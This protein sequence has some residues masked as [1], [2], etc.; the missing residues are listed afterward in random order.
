MAMQMSDNQ[1]GDLLSQQQQNR[2]WMQKNP[3]LGMGLGAGL[4]GLGGMFSGL[5]SGGLTGKREKTNQVPLY[6]PQIMA[7]KNQMPQE[8]WSQIMGN[9]FDFGPIEDLAR[10]NFQSKTMPSVMNRFNMGSNRG[11][12]NQQGALGAASSGLDAQLAAMRQGFGQQRQ[13]LLASLMGPALQPS[14]ENVARPRQQGG[15]EQGIGAILQMLPFLLSM[16]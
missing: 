12:S 4:A 14:F 2:P 5:M 8:L 10:Q 13:S 3:E 7:L 11:S 16:A 15:M 6:S 9:Q 1:F